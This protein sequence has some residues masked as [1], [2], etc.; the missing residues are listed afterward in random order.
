MP[1]ELIG[2]S[3]TNGDHFGVGLSGMRERV[4]DSGGKFDIQSTGDGTAML[5]S[6]PLA[7]EASDTRRSARKSS[8]A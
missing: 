3:R 5:V 8:A 6:I 2:G 7:V 4:N 1:A